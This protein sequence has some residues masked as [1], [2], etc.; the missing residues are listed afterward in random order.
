MTM[1]ALFGRRQRTRAQSMVEFALVLPLLLL[2]VVGIIELG[3]AL[4]VY[5][6]V[7]NAGRE[8]ARAAAVRACPNLTN[9]QE[10]ANLTRA[11]MPVFINF[12]NINSQV[13]YNGTVVDLDVMNPAPSPVVANPLATQN[14]GN[15]ITVTVQYSFQLLD[16]LTQKFIPQVNVNAVAG[17]TITTGCEVTS[18]FISF[19]TSTPTNTPTNTPTATNTPTPSNTSTPSNTP[20]ITQTPTRTGTPTNTSLPTP[21]NTRRPT[22]TPRPT[23]TI[24]QTP[25]NTATPT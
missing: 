19:I 4:F 21:T 3:Y 22:R 14:F 9:Y 23:A 16:P 12:A 17:R 25:T 11:R 8:G 5:V 20:T 10:I 13:A 18:G 6:E 1:R 7:Q 2:L 24:T 15:P